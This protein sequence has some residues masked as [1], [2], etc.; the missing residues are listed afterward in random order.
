MPLKKLHEMGEES[1]ITGDVPFWENAW[2]KSGL[3]V[4]RQPNQVKKM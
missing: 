2:I 3:S 4:T 1:F